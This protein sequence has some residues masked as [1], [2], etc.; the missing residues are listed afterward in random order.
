MKIRT[1]KT[2]SQAN[3]DSEVVQYQNGKRII[4]QHIGSA[5]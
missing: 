5:Q 2:A 4:M 3:R 1:V